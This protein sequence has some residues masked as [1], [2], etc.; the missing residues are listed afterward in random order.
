[1]LADLER[2]DYSVE[3]LEQEMLESDLAIRSAAGPKMALCRPG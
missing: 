1:M 3:E 2:W